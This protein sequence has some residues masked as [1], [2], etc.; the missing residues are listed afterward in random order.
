LSSIGA[1]LVEVCLVYQVFDNQVIP[2]CFLMCLCTI[3]L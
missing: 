2:H 3:L 1:L